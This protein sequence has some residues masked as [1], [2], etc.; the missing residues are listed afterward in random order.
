MPIVQYQLNSCVSNATQQI[1]YETWMGFLLR[2]HQLVRNSTAPAVDQCRQ[3][4]QAAWEQAVTAITH[5]QSLWQK[6]LTF[7]PYQVRERVWLEGVNLHT[8]HPVRKLHPK[9][10]GPFKVMEVLSLVTYRLQLPPSWQIHNT[11]H[12]TL[13][14][15][16]HETAEHG[17]SYP[18][19]APELIQG[20]PEWEV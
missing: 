1:P 17:V 19:P 8:S 3:Q 14:S 2:A 6:A 9:W 4:L 13:L 20:E 11:F 5:A 10:F 18:T 15:P 7:R 12:A 16:Y